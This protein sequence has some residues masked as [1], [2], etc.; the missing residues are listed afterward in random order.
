MGLTQPV[1]Q[2]RLHKPSWRERRRGPE[3]R[4]QCE[5]AGSVAHPSS[6]HFSATAQN[7][8]A[9]EEQRAERKIGK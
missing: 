5:E 2:V 1:V 9:G 4:A 3:T 6:Q 8:K 7:L